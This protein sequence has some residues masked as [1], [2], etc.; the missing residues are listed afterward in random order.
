MQADTQNYS[1]PIVNNGVSAEQSSPP[2]DTQNTLTSTTV[3]LR[4][5]IF[6]WNMNIFF[7]VIQPFIIRPQVV[8][9]TLTDENSI[10]VEK[11]S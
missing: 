2:I 3:R 6:L 9:S 8:E 4:K 1:L 11:G 7:F 10:S 5:K